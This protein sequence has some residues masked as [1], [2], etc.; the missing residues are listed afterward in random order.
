[1]TLL[2]FFRW[3]AHFCCQIDEYHFRPPN[4]EFDAATYTNHSCDGNVGWVDDGTR[5]VAIRDIQSGEEIT[6]DYATSEVRDYGFEVCL[7]GSEKCRKTL[8]YDDWK[9]PEVQAAYKGYFMSFI[10]DRIDKMGSM[11]NKEKE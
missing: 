7:C 3:V 6:F 1:M 2:F 5:M 11:S 9:L 10:Q 8:T 4:D